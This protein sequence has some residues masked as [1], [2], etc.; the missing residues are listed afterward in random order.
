VLDIVALEVSTKG[1]YKSGVILSVVILS[2]FD[3]QMVSE[4]LQEKY[5]EY[6]ADL[7][8]SLYWYPDHWLWV[9]SND[10][11]RSLC[12][13]LIADFDSKILEESRKLNRKIRKIIESYSPNK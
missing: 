1:G 4:M 10:H 7:T 6:G 8:K 11:L 3:N 13:D 12:V 2:P 9:G 5:K